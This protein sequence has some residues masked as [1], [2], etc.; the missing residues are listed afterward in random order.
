VRRTI[1]I[2]DENL[3]RWRQGRALAGRVDPS[4]GYRD[5]LADESS[6]LAIA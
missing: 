6:R 4:I 1:E 3:T 2:F 5:R